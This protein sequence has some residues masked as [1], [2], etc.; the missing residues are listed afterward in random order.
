MGLIVS[1]DDKFGMPSSEIELASGEHVLLTLHKHGLI[2]KALARP[3]ETERTIFEATP[4]TVAGICA[5]L[6]GDDTARTTPLQVL[7]AAT[8]RLPDV[9]AVRNAFETAADAS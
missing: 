1:Y 9:A 8:V 7:A 6:V 5:G 4:G 3:G 2:I